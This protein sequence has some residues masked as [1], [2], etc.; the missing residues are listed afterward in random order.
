MLTFVEIKEVF[1]IVTIFCS[2]LFYLDLCNILESAIGT[3]LSM[4]VFLD[5]CL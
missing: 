4:F 5:Q 3:E 2:K 1:K